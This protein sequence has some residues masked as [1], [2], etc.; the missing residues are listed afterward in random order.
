MTPPL[1]PRSAKEWRSYAR[2]R[3]LTH[4]RRHLIR[5]EL[6]ASLTEETTSSTALLPDL[7]H[8]WLHCGPYGDVAVELAAWRAVSEW[9]RRPVAGAMPVEKRRLANAE[10]QARAEQVRRYMG[11]I[12]AA[13]SVPALAGYM[14]LSAELST[15]EK[16][17]DK[18]RAQTAYREW[19]AQG[20]AGL[21]E[22]ILFVFK[23]I[24][25]GVR[26]ERR[27][28]MFTPVI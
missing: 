7:E 3:G 16:R 18:Q 1:V 24:N 17:S 22:A 27:P 21:N 12:A 2:E 13:A 25:S 15:A 10:R 4:L 6:P 5:A 19:L 8:L 26:L 9:V 11:V 20:S 28:R 14:Q 23:R